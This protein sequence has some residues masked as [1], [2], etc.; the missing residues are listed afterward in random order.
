MKNVIT[1]L[2]EV[3][4][5]FITLYR[6]FVLFLIVCIYRSNEKMTTWWKEEISYGRSTWGLGEFV[7]KLFF[8]YFFVLQVH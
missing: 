7:L 6:V 4:D 3:D 1:I 8:G 5:N 2:L